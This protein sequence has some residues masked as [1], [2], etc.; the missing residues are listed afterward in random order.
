MKPIL[1]QVPTYGDYSFRISNETVPHFYNPFHFH[2]ELEITYVLKSHGTRFIGDSIERFDI[3]D[4][5]LVGSNLPHC[6]KNE[7][8]YFEPG[9]DLEAQAIVIQFKADFAGQL[10]QLIE[11]QHIDQL[12]KSAT[13]GIKFLDKI[14]PVIK[15]K[16]FDLIESKG[17]RRVTQL[18]DLLEVMANTKEKRTLCKAYAITNITSENLGRLNKILE[19]TLQNYKEHITLEEISDLVH[20]TPN[21]FCRY[22]KLH[23]RKTYREFVNELRIANVCRLIQETSMS[24]TEI[25]FVSGFNNISHFIKTFK[26]LKKVKPTEYRKNTEGTL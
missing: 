18:I 14:K 9:T 10:F 11:L 3:D 1:I 8:E 17:A 21:A 13:Q 19:Y 26:K 15:Q 22:F 2:Q 7:A 20:L 12:I 6:W 4:L 24:M 5:V 25:A 23:T 16:L